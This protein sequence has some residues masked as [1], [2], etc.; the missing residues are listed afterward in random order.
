MDPTS[1]QVCGEQE[2]V[3]QLMRG[4]AHYSHCIS[5]RNPDETMPE[6][7]KTSFRAVLELRFYDADEREQ[8]GPSQTVQRIPEQKDVTGIVEFFGMTSGEATGYT[9]HCWQGISRSPAVALGLLYLMTGSEEEAARILKR[10]R[11]DARPHRK[12]V[13]FFD[14]QLGC[15]LTAVNEKIRAQASEAMKEERASPAGLLTRA[16]M[17]RARR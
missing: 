11:P 2:L 10:A 16:K 4:G 15:R 13:R 5:I 8:L 12:I 1:L 14:E 17:K 6:I 7:I 9:V 3:N